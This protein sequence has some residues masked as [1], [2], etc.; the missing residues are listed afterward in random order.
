MPYRR[1]HGTY[2]TKSD[3]F[4][5]AQRI[6]AGTGNPDIDKV[7]DLVCIYGKLFHA[8]WGVSGAAWLGKPLEDLYE[9]TNAEGFQ[10]MVQRFEH[11]VINCRSDG[12]N[13][14]QWLSWH[15]WWAISGPEVNKDTAPSI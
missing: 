13:N 10:I 3:L 12:A 6:A 15:D 9:T 11:G 2:E 1:S 7:S 5:T 14:V 4:L 8:W